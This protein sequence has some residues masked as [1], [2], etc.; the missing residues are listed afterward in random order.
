MPNT[1]SAVL[2]ALGALSG[3]S[4]N[5]AVNSRLNRDGNFRSVAAALFRG[6]AATAAQRTAA[7]TATASDNSATATALRL[8][9][10]MTQAEAAKLPKLLSTPANRTLFARLKGRG[11]TTTFT[12]EVPDLGTSN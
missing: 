9:L 10:D 3:P 7:T 5:A 2:T 6:R 11:L 12:P 4:I 8:A 1:A